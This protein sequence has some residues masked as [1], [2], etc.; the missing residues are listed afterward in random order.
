MGFGDAK[1]LR[2]NLCHQLWLGIGD[3]RAGDIVIGGHPHRR[4]RSAVDDLHLQRS[5]ML[6]I[7]LEFQTTVRGRG[8][9]DVLRQLIE[10]LIAAGEVEV[11][12]YA[13]FG[14]RRSCCNR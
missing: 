3:D 5:E 10:P 8:L 13:L 7:E 9:R 1:P 14:M 2:A 11:A 12:R 4:P 6:R